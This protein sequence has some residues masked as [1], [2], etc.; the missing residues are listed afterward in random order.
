MPLAGPDPVRSEMMPG[1][2]WTT[3]DAGRQ[4]RPCADF[5]PLRRQAIPSPAGFDLSLTLGF[6]AAGLCAFNKPFHPWPSGTSR[7][8][9]GLSLRIKGCGRQPRAG[10]RPYLFHRPGLRLLRHLEYMNASSPPNCILLNCD[11]SLFKP[12]PF[13]IAW[14]CGL[15]GLLPCCDTQA[16]SVR[17][18]EK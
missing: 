7:S 11:E 3:T 18:R 12:V 15:P 10:W 8:K 14:G 4:G 1:P 17:V 16:Q 2:G 13:I 6:M 9:T 5:S